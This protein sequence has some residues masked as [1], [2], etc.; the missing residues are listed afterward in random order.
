MPNTPADQVA[1]MK[2]RGESLNEESENCCWRKFLEIRKQTTPIMRL[3]LWI[4]AIIDPA[5]RKI[6]AED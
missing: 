4:D 6:I 3:R 1:G 2:A 5:I